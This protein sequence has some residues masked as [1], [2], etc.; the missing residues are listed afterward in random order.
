MLPHLPVDDVLPQITATLR[1]TRNLVIEAPAGAGKTTRV[2]RALLHHGQVLVLEPRR[3][4]A[5]L[6]ARRVAQELGEAIGATVGYQ[7]RFEDA[8]SSRT[9]LRFLTE[10]ILTRRL[11]DDPQLQGVQTIILDEFHERHLEGDLALALLRRLQLTTRPDL[12]IVVMS[13][14]LDAG[15]IA[16]YLEAPVIRSEGRLYPLDITYTPYS[17][18]SLEEQVAAA[19][20]RLASD[21]GDILVFLPGAAEIRRAA[22]ACER[23]TGLD[24]LPLYGDLSPEEQDRAVSPSTKRKLVL[25]T[26]VAESSITIEGIA[27][28]IDSGLARI[29][30]DSPW[31]GL[32]TLEIQRIS[33]ASANQRAGRAG[34][35]AP[36]RVIRLYTAEDFA[37]RR[38]Q[39]PPEIARR[40]L[41]SV[42]LELKALGIDNLPWF[43]SPPQAAI[44]NAN[45][46]LHALG[47]D[48]GAR[49]LA[50]LPLHPRL[51]RMVL[52]GGYPA[53]VLA[54]MLSVNERFENI[55]VLH[56]VDR[57]PS[58]SAERA[59]RQIA[60]AAG[61]RC[62][63]EHNDERLARAVLRAFP[64]RVAKRRNER[65][66]QFSSGAVA[67]TAQPV[68]SA[69][70]VVLD[71]ED[72]RE[73]NVPFVRAVAPI[74]PDWLLDLFP[75]RIT[76]R[77]E[78]VWNREAER[79]E[80]RSALLF[81]EL[82]IEESR[83]GAVH[84]GQA[85]ELLALKAIEAGVERLADIEEIE[86]FLARVE[87]ASR[88]SAVPK[89]TNEDIEAA[90][91]ELSYGLKSLNDLRTAAK[92]G[93][94]VRALR[95]RLTPAQQ[96]ELDEVAPERYLLKGRQ[97]RI[98]YKRG[99]TPHLASRLQ[100]FFGIK[101]S[102][103][104]ARGEVPLLLHLLAPNQRPVQMTTDLPGFW[105]RLY[106]QVRRELS[107]RYPKHAWPEIPT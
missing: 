56:A 41:S 34:R 42:V 90:L 91:R 97:T 40:E 64:D 104:I 23:L 53:C 65:E 44:D 78:T 10:G 24:I 47:A 74:K 84:A 26:N 59:I 9:R 4:A 31:T 33:K 83:S 92:E 16:N 72:R 96:R 36:G 71:V 51:S 37:R 103:K 17:P 25:S 73:H 55:D 61:V 82:T 6:A 39:D 2:P 30:S 28:V 99:Q 49:A 81:D 98:H 35:T 54:G 106:P 93:G 100:D 38:D 19:V 68:H 58:Y 46:L 43:E 21:P 95:N 75:D 5:R 1:A 60:R 69:F 14:T 88:H 13:A 66:V 8:T 3:L 105:T 50:A 80:T 11:L 52:E 102:P 94:L 27:C 87:F 57:P 86:A 20:E 48:T 77:L 32:P 70:V 107:R 89:L 67:A 101:E 29:A 12:R 22:R 79:V 76:E 62:R 18:A 63:Q 15:L 7:V 85:A 45:A